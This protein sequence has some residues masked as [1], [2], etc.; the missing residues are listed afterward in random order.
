[1]HVHENR[2]KKMRNFNLRNLRNAK[3]KRFGLYHI[4]VYVN[5]KHLPLNYSL[6]YLFSL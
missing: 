1:M 6:F 4:R 3:T 5:L 2:K